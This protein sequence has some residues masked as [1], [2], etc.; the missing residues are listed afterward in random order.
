MIFLLSSRGK[1]GET[2]WRVLKVHLGNAG[3]SPP[4]KIEEPH[5]SSKV[6]LWE[7]ECFFWGIRGNP[8]LMSDQVE[9]MNAGEIRSLTLSILYDIFG[10]K[11]I[12]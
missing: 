5:V 6:N 7:M 2:C 8:S 4:P 9:I 12:N 10:I 3:S 11:F 1:P